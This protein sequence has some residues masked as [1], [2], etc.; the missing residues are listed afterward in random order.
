MQWTLHS[1][2]KATQL[3]LII[4]EDL[5]K[6]INHLTL[7]LS[8]IMKNHSLSTVA[9]KLH[10]QFAH[11]PANLLICLVKS[12][13][14]P[15]ANDPDLKGQLKS[16]VHNCQTCKLLAFCWKKFKGEDNRPLFLK[17]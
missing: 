9:D 15:W 10:C 11:H 17:Q 6:D 2:T 8:Q 14:S 4:G 7:Y 16:T 5:G 1:P 13:G 3:L 12:A